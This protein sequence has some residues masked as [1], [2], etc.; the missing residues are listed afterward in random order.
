MPR[1]FMLNNNER[2]FRMVS[3]CF[4]LV[5]WEKRAFVQRDRDVQKHKVAMHQ[6]L[7]IYADRMMVGCGNEHEYTLE[8]YTARRKSYINE[9]WIK[10]E[11][12][13]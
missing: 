7:R 9:K 4:F 11:D 2:K 3:V 10:V 12:K 6:I 1:P 5:W 13:Y 8:G